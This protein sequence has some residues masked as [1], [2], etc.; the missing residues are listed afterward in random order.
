MKLYTIPQAAE[1]LLIKESTLRNLIKAHR[2]SF[3]K[4]RPNRLLERHLTDYLLSQEVLCEENQ[5]SSSSE[6]NP[7]TSSPPIGTSDITMDEVNVRL[8]AVESARKTMKPRSSFIHGAS[9]GNAQP[10]GSQIG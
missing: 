9:K 3:V 8:R 2:I 10:Q 5:S 4:G 1:F 6:T 7:E